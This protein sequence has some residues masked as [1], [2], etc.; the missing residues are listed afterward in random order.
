MKKNKLI[1][2]GDLSL[3]GSFEEKIRNND[4]I[5]SNEILDILNSA[6]HCVCNLEGPVTNRN[7]YANPNLKVTSP[8][9][10][11][12]YLKER[13]I[14]VFNLANNHIFDSGKE[15]FLDTIREIN[16]KEC[17]YF[18]AWLKDESKNNSITIGKDIKIKLTSYTEKIKNKEGL[19]VSTQKH[20]KDYIKQEDCWEILFHHGGEEYTLYPST[21]KRKHLKKI[22]KKFTPDFLISHHS[23]T[24]QGAEKFG[25]TNIFYSLGNFIFDIQPHHY[26]NYTDES[27]ILVISFHNDSYQYELIPIKINRKDGLI[28]LGDQDIINRFNSISDFSNYKKKWQQEAHRTL[29]ERLPIPEEQS[30]T[31][32]LHKKS[33]FSLLFDPKFYAKAF[34]IIFDTNN[35]SIYWNAFIYKLLNKPSK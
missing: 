17:F 25:K 20:I 3:T 9:N 22:Q 19:L 8:P 35:R 24:L 1:I 30:K 5:F 12:S 16:N 32:P 15:G 2:T 4:E 27:A 21:T 18:G 11:I 23:H 13:N 31:T 10:S 29:V 14:K 34:K 6:D 26:Y 33:S 28:E 7:H